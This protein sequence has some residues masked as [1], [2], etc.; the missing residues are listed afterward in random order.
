MTYDEIV[1]FIVD[2][3]KLELKTQSCYTGSSDG[4]M[5]EDRKTVQLTLC[6]NAISEVDV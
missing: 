6:G 3:L 4:P 2:N 5:Y 1:R